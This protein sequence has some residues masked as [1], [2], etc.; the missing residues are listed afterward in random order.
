MLGLE[1]GEANIGGSALVKS[2]VSSS[3][4]GLGEVASVLVLECSN[5]FFEISILGDI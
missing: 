5:G 2:V 4:N 1:I 3:L